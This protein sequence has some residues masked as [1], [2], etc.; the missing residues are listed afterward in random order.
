MISTDFNFEEYER[1]RVEKHEAEG[2]RF[3]PEGVGPKV[4]AVICKDKN[5]WNEIH[6]YIIEENE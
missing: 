1:L 6:N 5:D 2:L 3:V 4:Y